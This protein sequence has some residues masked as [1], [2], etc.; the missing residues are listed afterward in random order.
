[1]RL[2][3]FDAATTL[4]GEDGKPNAELFLSDQLHLN[5]KGY[6]IWTGRLRPIIRD[7]MKSRG[8]G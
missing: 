3:F 4:L 2:F 5:S 7:A 8:K 1:M 6:K